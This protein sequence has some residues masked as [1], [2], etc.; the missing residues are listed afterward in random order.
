MVCGLLSTNAYEWINFI[1]IHT[2]FYCAYWFVFVAAHI[3]ETR[4]SA[5]HNLPKFIRYNLWRSISILFCEQHTCTNKMDI[6]QIPYASRMNSTNKE[7]KI[8]KKTNKLH[9]SGK[10]LC[11]SKWFRLQY[12]SFVYL[13]SSQISVVEGIFLIYSPGRAC[14]KLHLNPAISW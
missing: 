1:R 8:K 12:F 9:F 7:V 4:V 5:F 3:R 14:I 11:Y 10:F 2:I 6:K 13:T